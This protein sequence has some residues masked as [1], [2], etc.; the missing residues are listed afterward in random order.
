MAAARIGIQFVYVIAKGTISVRG[1]SN[2]VAFN[3]LVRGARAGACDTA[4]TASFG[5]GVLDTDRNASQGITLTPLGTLYDNGV[6]DL[7]Q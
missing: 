3:I 1:T 2:T 6:L 7:T 4:E 5:C